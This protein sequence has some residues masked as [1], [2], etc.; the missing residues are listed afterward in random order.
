MNSPD[1]R[2]FLEHEHLLLMPEHTEWAHMARSGSWALA[3]LALVGCAHPSTSPGEETC[4]VADTIACAVQCDEGTVSA[5]QRLKQWAPALLDEQG[6]VAREVLQTGCT[7]G[8]AEACAREALHLFN[9]GQT[10]QAYALVEPVCKE[11][12][13][14]ACDVAAEIAD[15]VPLPSRS[16]FKPRT[17][18]AL[19]SS[20][21]PSSAGKSIAFPRVAF[22]AGT[23]G[24]TELLVGVR[25]DGQ[26]VDVRIL[27]SA[28][29]AVLDRA[30]R[31]AVRR[32]VWTP[33]IDKSGT[34]VDGLAR[35][36]VQFVFDEA[37]I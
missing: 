31:F 3:L 23:N 19:R 13:W 28:G 8:H 16:D 6:H 18:A 24:S 5:C 21:L 1:V 15:A 14:Y 11:H 34:A 9:A 25:R 10:A 7:H 33:A 35:Y 36:R 2:F 32:L 37:R 27:K 22:E 4:S 30:A 29:A 12:E 26:V 17:V 20:P